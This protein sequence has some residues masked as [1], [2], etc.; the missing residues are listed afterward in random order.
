[1]HMEDGQNVFE[2]NPGLL[3]FVSPTHG[4]CTEEMAEDALKD[5]QVSP[6]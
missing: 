2:S 3:H 1:M 4:L 5:I 6:S